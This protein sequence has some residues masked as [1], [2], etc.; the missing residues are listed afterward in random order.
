[1]PLY[2]RLCLKDLEKLADIMSSGE[3]NLDLSAALA[4]TLREAGVPAES[5]AWVE[6]STASSTDRFFSYRAEGGTCGRHGALAV[7]LGP[8]G[9]GAVLE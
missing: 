6:E 8:D 9:K 2:K 5:V 3:R 1:M 7:I 4:V